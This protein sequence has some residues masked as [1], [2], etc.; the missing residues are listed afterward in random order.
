VPHAAPAIKWGVDQSPSVNPLVPT[1]NSRYCVGD[2]TYAGVGK[3]RARSDQSPKA[4]GGGGVEREF[5]LAKVD[6]MAGVRKSRENME[7]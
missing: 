4:E 7:T 3:R 6:G 5:D 1:R 2:F